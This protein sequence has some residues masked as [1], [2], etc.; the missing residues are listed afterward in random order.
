M[1]FKD[2]VAGP[3]SYQSA[4]PNHDANLPLDVKIII[5]DILGGGFKCFLCSPKFGADSQF[6]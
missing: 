1:V 3:K 6:D 2:S 4:F 5:N